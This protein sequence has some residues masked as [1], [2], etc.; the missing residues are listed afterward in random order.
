MLLA[1]NVDAAAVGCN[2]EE[3][4]DLNVTVSPG[5]DWEFVTAC[6]SWA[7]FCTARLWPTGLGTGWVAVEGNR[8][9]LTPLN[10]E[11]PRKVVPASAKDDWA[12]NVNGPTAGFVLGPLATNNGVPDDDCAVRET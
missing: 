2:G 9:E 4:A 6:W 8:N 5:L 7:L 10:V 1:V 11:P 12:V 3:F